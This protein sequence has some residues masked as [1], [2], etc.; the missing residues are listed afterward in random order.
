[1]TTTNT[2]TTTTTTTPSTSFDRSIFIAA[3]AAVLAK[4]F[5]PGDAQDAAALNIPA[6]IS[7]SDERRVY[8]LLSAQLYAGDG[9]PATALAW[10]IRHA[11]EA[12]VIGKPSKVRFGARE[13]SGD[14]ISAAERETRQ[15]QRR[16]ASDRI[17][18]RQVLA[19]ERLADAVETLLQV[20]IMK[21][22]K[23]NDISDIKGAYAALTMKR[24]EA[25]A[26]EAKTEA[27]AEAKAK[28]DAKA[29]V[30]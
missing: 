26:A 22:G 11:F 8:A 9:K 21:D 30:A 15:V 27:K 6:S 25:R 7:T 2:T 10:R 29:K 23:G 1:M 28:D 3:V 18:E 24:A 17:A 13:L 4:A 14:S 16:M 20:F 19:T 12:G 5:D